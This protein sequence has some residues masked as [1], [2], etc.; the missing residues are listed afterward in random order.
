MRTVGNAREREESVS[1]GCGARRLLPDNARLGPGQDALMYLACRIRLRP[2]ASQRM[3]FART[4]GCARWAYNWGLRRK[5]EAYQAAGQ[6]PSAIDL[7]RELNRLKDA[8]VEEGGVPWM[9]EVSKCAPQEALRDLDAAFRHFFRRVRR[10][11]SLASRS[12]SRNGP[13]KGTSG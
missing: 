6:S 9:R 3:A 4:S 2:T 12:S 5:I 13:V 10:A 11:R 8:A 1:L 7:H